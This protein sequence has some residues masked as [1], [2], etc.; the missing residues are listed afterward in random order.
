MLL[1]SRTRHLCV[2]DSAADLTFAAAM[3]SAPGARAN[4]STKCLSG[5]SS[6]GQRTEE[7][8]RR[9][10]A[11]QLSLIGLALIQSAAVDGCL[12]GLDAPAPSGLRG[13]RVGGRLRS[14]AVAWFGRGGKMLVRRP[15]GRYLGPRPIF[16][17]VRRSATLE[18]GPVSPNQ[19][20]LML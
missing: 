14:G 10:E 3:A 18:S 20:M 8:Q 16:V 4:C 15:V 2:T 11:A 9:L 13:R 19:R 6:V 7:R 5:G 12:C 1:A 17:S